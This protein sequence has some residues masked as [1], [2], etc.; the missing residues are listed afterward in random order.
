MIAQKLGSKD[1]FAFDRIRR[2]LVH[3]A[4]D[5]KTIVLEAPFVNNDVGGEDGGLDI[6]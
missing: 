6:F 3:V 4:I 2:S 5:T 1:L